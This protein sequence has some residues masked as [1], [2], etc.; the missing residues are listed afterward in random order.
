[1]KT[2][3]THSFRFIF[4]LSQRQPRNSIIGDEYK[5]PRTIPYYM[6]DDLGKEKLLSYFTRTR[7]NEAAKST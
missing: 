5:W 1:M 4:L 6:E 7:N 2:A 3:V